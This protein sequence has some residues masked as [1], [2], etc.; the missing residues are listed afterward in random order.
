MQ[1]PMVPSTPAMGDRPSSAAAERRMSIVERKKRRS[2]LAAGDSLTGGFSFGGEMSAEASAAAAAARAAA[3]YADAEV[4]PAVAMNTTALVETASLARQQCALALA[5]IAMAGAASGSHADRARLLDLGVLG[6]LVA[7][8]GTGKAD[9]ANFTDTA[10]PDSH[11]GGESEP[12]R[13]RVATALQILASV[14][15]LA[16][17]L[18]SQ[19]AVPALVSLCGSSS[20]RV[21]RQA[22][23][24]LANL[25]RVSGAE[26]SLLEAGVVPALMVI[27]LLRS[28]DPVTQV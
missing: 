6:A 2:S 20:E 9:T 16:A 10:R 27:A 7:L 25:S 19:G 12:L 21:R 23:S 11:F 18:I 14:P 4:D 26:A 5:A 15:R 24:A 13:D 8:C 22:V 28:N 3:I 17:A 1:S